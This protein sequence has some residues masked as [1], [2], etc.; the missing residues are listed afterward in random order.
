MARRD[1]T[2]AHNIHRDVWYWNEKEKTL[3]SRSDPFK[4]SQV[5]KTLMTRYLP[6]A[7]VIT[8]AKANATRAAAMQRLKERQ[9]TNKNVVHTN[10]GINELGSLGMFRRAAEA[11]GTSVVVLSK[12]IVSDK[13]RERT[14]S[15][16]SVMDLAYEELRTNLRLDKCSE[17]MQNIKTKVMTINSPGGQVSRVEDFC[18]LVNQYR[19]TENFSAFALALVNYFAAH[20][21]MEDLRRSENLKNSSIN[22]TKAEQMNKE[23]QEKIDAFQ[24][25]LG[26]K[27]AALVLAVEV[28]DD[29]FHH[30]D[31]GKRRLYSY[32]VTDQLLHEIILEYAA[33]IVYTVFRSNTNVVFNNIKIELGKILRT[34]YFNPYEHQAVQ[35]K[36]EAIQNPGTVE[37]TIPQFARK[38]SIY[39]KKDALGDVLARQS[40]AS[41]LDPSGRDG[42][43]QSESSESDSEGSSTASSPVFACKKRL[44]SMIEKK[45]TMPINMRAAAERRIKGA[46][47]PMAQVIHQ[48]SSIIASALKDPIG[49]AVLDSRDF[50]LNTNMYSLNKARYRNSMHGTMTD[51]L[52]KSIKER[53]TRPRKEK[54]QPGANSM[55]SQRASRVKGDGQNESPRNQFPIAEIC[56]TL[57][58]KNEISE[59]L[60]RAS[61][62]VSI[63]TPLH[64]RPSAGP[65]N[66]VSRNRVSFLPNSKG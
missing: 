31:F 16:D 44:V 54:R 15:L 37:R 19:K 4:K 12:S 45:D 39:F 59:I 26:N 1:S 41:Q 13:N 42:D 51:N 3:S 43:T 48:N 11:A 22:P 66:T 58:R 53:L 34:D 65:R 47:P 27:Y 52:R 30:M 6:G 63:K 10:K 25:T 38:M 14:W 24:K 20:F 35:K 40:V 50:E 46:R 62:R 17:F 36:L 55:S 9:G 28:K 21:E 8:R 32:T 57:Q 23:A 64:S 49:M 56:A 2:S 7:A 5:V 60:G 61:N 29:I 18:K 33:I